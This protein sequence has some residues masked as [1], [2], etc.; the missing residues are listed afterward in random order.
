MF[1]CELYTT[2]E[3]REKL[4]Q[5]RDVRAE[6]Y[7]GIKRRTKQSDRNKQRIPN[8]VFEDGLT[9]S[10]A[11]NRNDYQKT[12]KVIRRYKAQDAL[13]FLMAERWLT[14][15]MENFAGKKFKLKNIMPD[16][17]NGI[18]SEVMPI[19]FKFYMNK[20]WYT[21]HSDAMKIKNYGDFY[22]LIH[23][24][25]L[26][27]LLELV[28]S[29][30]IEKESIETEFENYDDS[31]Y[32]VVKLVFDFEKLVYEKYPDM[33][34]YPVEKDKFD[35]GDLLEELVTRGKFTKNDTWVLSQI[36]NAFGHNSYP[37]TG[38]VKIK[39]LPEIA[40]HLIN[41]FESRAKIE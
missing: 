10:L 36:R 1:I 16:S 11:N 3:E 4:W 35:F 28:D 7:K 27:S 12:E 21:F 19:D 5:E 32:E 34:N 2:V 23:D 38:A 26:S 25:R 8:E 31:R 37:K 18:L 24:K 20:K 14:T 13:L 29:A 22:T 17:D 40:Q 39:V 9:K 30:T 15:N 6:K 33:K 41:V